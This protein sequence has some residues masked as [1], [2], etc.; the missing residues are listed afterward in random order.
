MFYFITVSAASLIIA[1]VNFLIGRAYTLLAFGKNLLFVL[2]GVAAVITVDGLFAFVIRRLPERLF[3]PEAELFSVGKRERGLYRKIKII[4]WKRYIP[5]WGCFTGFHKDKLREP[6]DSAYI[7]RF[8]IESNYGVAGHIAGAVFGFA[9]I[10][11]PFLHPLYV[12]L[13]IACVNFILSMLPTMILRSNTPALRG[14][15]RRNLERERGS[16]L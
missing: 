3:S 8:L 6:H 9:I 10:F 4:K 15:Y 13:P 12:A 16:L 7:G 14:L 1:T 2:I 11:I 5:E